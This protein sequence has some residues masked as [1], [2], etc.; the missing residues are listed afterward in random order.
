MKKKFLALML[1]VMLILTALPL[2]VAAKEVNSSIKNE[3]YEIGE[4]DGGL[5]KIYTLADF[6]SEDELKE[7][8]NEIA[9]AEGEDEF[10]GPVIQSTPVGSTQYSKPTTEKYPTNNAPLKLKLAI[11]VADRFFKKQTIDI[12]FGDPIKYPDKATKIA[13]FN[14]DATDANEDFNKVIKYYD[15]T[16]VDGKE[17][18]G[19]EKIA[20]SP[21]NIVFMVPYNF[22]YDFTLA[23]TK[24]EKNTQYAEGRQPY[25]QF[26]V[27]MRQ[28]V[29]HG[30]SIKWLDSNKGNRENVS[31]MWYGK[32]GNLYTAT[33]KT[34]DSA[35]SVYNRN[36]YRDQDKINKTDEDG[37]T[38]SSYPYYL[39]TWD[40]NADGGVGAWTYEIIETRAYPGLNSGV[41][42]AEKLVINDT[43]T[44]PQA[45]LYVDGT[46]RQGEK[47]LKNNTKYFYESTGDYKTLHVLTM[48][49]ALKVNFNTGKG[50]LNDADMSAKKAEQNIKVKVKENNTEVEKDF[51]EIGYGE[52]IKGNQAGGKNFD[53]SVNKAREITVPDGSTLIPPAAEAGKP[54]NEFKGWALTADATTAL[55]TS[56]SDAKKYTNE[57]KKD[58]TFYA[59]YGPKAQGKVN[60]KYV[61]ESGNPISQDPN[62]KD[63]RFLTDAE[64]KNITAEKT[65]VM[66]LAEKYPASM[67]DTLGKKVL[68]PTY[69]GDNDKDETKATDTATDPNKK[70]YIA[71]R[72]NA[73]KFIGY[74]VKKVEVVNKTGADQNYTPQFGPTKDD[75]GQVITDITKFDTIK[76]VYKKLDPIIPE[77]KNGQDNPDVTQDIKDT[78]V[79]VTFTNGLTDKK[80]GKLYLGDTEP[81]EKNKLIESVSYYVNP[82]EKKTIENVKVNENVNVKVIDASKK[83][84]ETT[85]WIDNNSNEIKLTKEITDADKKDGITVNANYDDKGNGV[86]AIR[87]VVK[88]SS[89]TKTTIDAKYQAVADTNKY[90]STIQG[91]LGTDVIDY[92][93]KTKNKKFEAPKFVGYTYQSPELLDSNK[94]KFVDDTSNDKATLDL[95]YTKEAEIIEKKDGTTIPDGYVD[96]TFTNAKDGSKIVSKLNSQTDAA[97]IVY[98]INPKAEVKI[99]KD[100]NS[101]PNKY[102]L[103]GKD[104][105]N[106][107]LK[108]DVPV[109]KADEGYKVKD[110][111]NNGAA[112]GWNY[113]NYDLVST[114]ETEKPLTEA[115]TFTAQVEQKGNG[116]AKLAYVDDNNATLDP[117]NNVKLQVANVNYNPSLSG[118]DGAALPSYTVQTAPKV[119]GYVFDTE[120][121]KQ[122]NN[123]DATQYKEG[124]EAVI[125]LKYKKLA[126]VYKG[127][128]DGE[129]DTPDVPGNDS[130]KDNV[131]NTVKDTYVKVKFLADEATRTSDADT[132][133]DK[134]NYRRGKLN[135][136]ENEV[137][138]Y[139]NPMAQN[140][141]GGY[142]STSADDGK[143]VVPTIKP[144]DGY[145]KAAQEWDPDLTTKKSQAVDASKKELTFTAQ[146]VQKGTGYVKVEYWADGTKLDSIEDYKLPGK[147]YINQKSG[148]EDVLVQASDL[149]NDYFDLLGYKKDTDIG[150]NGI[151]V[152]A[153]TKYLTENLG[154]VKF[155]YKKIDDIIKPNNPSETIPA[156][157]VAVKFLADEEGRATARGNFVAD[158]DPLVYYVNPKTVTIDMA[159]QKL[160]G[161]DK[162]GTAMEKPF[163]T[164]TVTDNNFVANKE[165]NGK[166]DKNGT[167]QWLAAGNTLT[168]N[169]LANTNTGITLTAMY[170]GKFN[171]TYK[172]VIIPQG[173]ELPKPLDD[174]TKAVTKDLKDKTGKDALKPGTKVDNP[175]EIDLSKLSEEDKKLVGNE[176]GQWSVSKWVKT[177]DNSGNITFTL[178]WTF[179]EAGK[180]YEYLTLTLDENYRGGRVSDYD[181]YRGDLIEGYL[182][183]PHRKGYVFEGWS[184]NSR[185]LDEVR[186]GD[187]IEYSTILYA[188]WSK[189]KPKDDEEVEPIDTREVGE[190]K[191]YMFGYTDGTVR[192]NG[193]ITRAEA[194]A[195]VTRLLGLDTFASAAEP[196]FTDTPSSWY[197]K[198]INAAVARGIMKGYPDKSFRPNAP[199]TRAEFTQMISTIDNKPYGVAP[200][201]DVVGHWAERPIGSEYQAGRIKG[202]PDGTFRPNAFITRA[203]AVVILNKIFERNYDAMSAMNAKNKEYIKRFI[204]LAP[205]F[206]GFNDMV[207]ATNTHL[208]KRRV[209]GRVEEDWV[210][211]K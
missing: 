83:V 204:D 110:H 55:F 125:T 101:N 193:Y 86:A 109:V 132:D 78:Y 65:E 209:P 131:I 100:T 174:A 119:L 72:D 51:Q 18:F 28:S 179:T 107:D 52:K 40:P 156:G 20:Q 102:Q 22:T 30:Y 188:I 121:S 89:G 46:S 189:Q 95:V 129:N 75:Q 148:E 181:A 33:L 120:V 25:L 167:Q 79:K 96:I 194:A 19:L 24:V 68:A 144:N 136:T 38:Y 158:D 76:Y 170:L 67:S 112:T 17:A 69:S 160:S 164:L 135:S 94:S 178:T 114:T 139:I 192:P 205:S 105:K 155:H 29:M 6:M 26:E 163:P 56:D 180:P 133:K 142:I 199:I 2:E 140:N 10:L 108:K 60:V 50:F 141:L 106:V 63:Y 161:T 42:Q 130:N 128:K 5:N 61:D 124:Q 41:F 92:A 190:H 206:W 3:P 166:Y 126:D 21:G 151:E 157:Y 80:F 54:A 172:V 198:A 58:T 183:R 173:K 171:V 137:F 159:G 165:T 70:S 134:D 202:Y 36:Q 153:N 115:K 203:E 7:F 113:N 8:A 73:P 45:G 39:N 16:W 64:K 191:A 81:T 62:G 196:A 116:T 37:V 84:H 48:R 195:L 117:A 104:A 162:N 27:E 118:K 150:T 169:K 32:Q 93:N 87:Y 98:S 168:N 147:T 13:E 123:A 176:V 210:E 53:Y 47:T 127:K 91:T 14:I 71:T 201:A 138:Y 35:Y 11:S 49:E 44:A 197:N 146:Y 152:A 97:D 154:T 74:E 182:Y 103:V 99:V 9:N 111:Q 211:V 175:A 207:E 90:P 66:L 184:Y 23:S 1:S 59:I 187:R 185:R 4:V 186:P 82:R 15:A 57:F 122:I 200:F 177:Q 85:P 12:Y 31:A 88:N 208:F 43:D 77:K 145:K 149:T 34:I 143:I